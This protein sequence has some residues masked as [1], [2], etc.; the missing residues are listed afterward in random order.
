MSVRLTDDYRVRLEAFEGPLD[1][2][3]FLIRKH[4]VEI[5][6]I[7]VA[8]IA[9]EY[10][11]F[12]S[13]VPEVDIEA[14]GEFLVMAATLMEIKSRM[15]M[16]APE[17]EEAKAA[18]DQTPKEGDDPRAGLVRQLLEFKKYRDAA[19]ELEG[20]FDQWQKRFP[21]APPRVD[22]DSLR[23][24]IEE[25]Q[26]TEIELEDIGLGDLVEAFRAIMDTVNL[27]RLGEH[28]VTYDET[29]V[30][31]HAEDMMDW[32]GR[33]TTRLASVEAAGEATN[34]RGPEIGGRPSVEFSRLFIGRKRTE[35]VGLFLALLQLVK[36]RRVRVRQ[37]AIAAK[38]YIAIADEADAAELPPTA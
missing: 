27:E 26:G 24:A 18:A 15:L 4:E 8:V 14:A 2:L 5:T 3:L 33:E 21:V 30:E 31:L 29:P 9:R 36:N 19:M 35:M 34:E 38:I 23:K 25:A 20:R 1:L 28:Q 10:M 7:P 16:P 22:D 32:L 37:D 12:L 11:G 6:D 13:Q 17:G